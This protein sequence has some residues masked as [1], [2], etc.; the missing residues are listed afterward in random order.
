ML[1]PR[2]LRALGWTGL[3]FFAFISEQRPRSQP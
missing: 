1:T 2:V 3:F